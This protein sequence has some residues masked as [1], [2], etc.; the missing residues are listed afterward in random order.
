MDE[1][2]EYGLPHF[3]ADYGLVKELFSAFRTIW[4]NHE[5]DFWERDG[6]TFSSFHYHVL[7][8]KTGR[9]KRGY[10]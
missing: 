6:N 5:E 8:Q 9:E 1:G 3:Y 7:A 4:I 10:D 2:P